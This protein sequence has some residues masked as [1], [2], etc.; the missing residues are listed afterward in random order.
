M[1]NKIVPLSCIETGNMKNKFCCICQENIDLDKHFKPNTCKHSWCNEC[2]KNYTDNKCPICRTIFRE[3][4][5]RNPEVRELQIN[6]V[7]VRPSI[8]FN[9]V[10]NENRILRSS[11]INRRNTIINCSLLCLIINCLESIELYFSPIDYSF[12]NYIRVFC[13]ERTMCVYKF[14]FISIFFTCHK[15][16]CSNIKHQFVPLYR[17]F[18]NE[19][20]NYICSLFIFTFI[21]SLSIMGGRILFL[22][23][24]PHVSNYFCDFGWF[25]ISSLIGIIIFAMYIILLLFSI[26]ILI[27]IFTYLYKCIT[28]CF[29]QIIDRNYR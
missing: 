29:I 22:I 18:N 16:K 7:S 15:Y 11:T 10:Y 19:R 1:N 12:K 23:V 6:I 9:R 27:Q 28:C 26:G 8:N 21:L 5:I 17:I 20:I 3:T 2:N 4:S 14:P 25:V 13:W 24:N